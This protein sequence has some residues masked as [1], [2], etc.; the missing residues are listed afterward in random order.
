MPYTFSP[1]TISEDWQRCYEA[2][3]AAKEQ[4]ALF[5]TFC[6]EACGPFFQHL[7]ELKSVFKSVHGIEF[8]PKKPI[9]V[10]DPYETAEEARDFDFSVEAH[11]SEI[12]AEAYSD[13]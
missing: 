8:D 5:G 6:P 4:W 3:T 12:K 9:V 11:N 13:A 7:S 2:H 1:K 10:A